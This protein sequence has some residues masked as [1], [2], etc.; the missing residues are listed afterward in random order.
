[1][2]TLYE[3]SFKSP[4]AEITYYSRCGA[5]GATWKP[6]SCAFELDET[7]HRFSRIRSN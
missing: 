6:D 7:E 5:L 4:S 2:N 3:V 1:M